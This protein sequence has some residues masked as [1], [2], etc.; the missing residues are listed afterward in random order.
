M[1]KYLKYSMLALLFISFHTNATEQYGLAFPTL[2]EVQNHINDEFKNTVEEQL[3]Q[4]GYNVI[5]KIKGSYKLGNYEKQELQMLPTD[6]YLQA[7]TMKMVVS[8]NIILQ[9]G[10]NPDWGLYPLALICKNHI[11]IIEVDNKNTAENI[12]K[13]TS[14]ESCRPPSNNF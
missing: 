14:S 6:N 4:K 7:L 8:N 10:F 9:N 11:Y 3:A 2:N 12:I 13:K 5:F 1:K